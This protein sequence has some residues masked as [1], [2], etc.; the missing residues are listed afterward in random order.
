MPYEVKLTFGLRT[1]TKVYPSVNEA[2]ISADRLATSHA[3]KFGRATATVLSET[4]E[5]IYIR[6]RNA[7]ASTGLKKI[8]G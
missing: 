1:L 5:E 4:G 8:S 6:V 7:P 3:G 2:R